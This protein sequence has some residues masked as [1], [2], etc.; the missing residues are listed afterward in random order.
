MT[1]PYF[2]L[3]VAR[4]EKAFSPWFTPDKTKLISKDLHEMKLLLET[5]VK[6]GNDS[7]V[8]FEDGCGFDYFSNIWN[9]NNKLQIGQEKFTQVE[10]K[11]KEYFELS[12]TWLLGFYNSLNAYKNFIAINSREVKMEDFSKGKNN[13]YSINLGKGFLLIYP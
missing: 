3:T 6:V 13:P 11:Y 7:I 2:D 1:D 5:M 4:F 9:E 10:Q 8:E 12:P